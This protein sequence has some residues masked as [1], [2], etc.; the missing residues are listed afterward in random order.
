MKIIETNLEGCII[1]EPTIFEDKRGYFFESFNHQVFN[2]ITNFN[3]VFVQDNEAF[4]RKGAL[5]GMHYQVGKYSQ[6]KLVRVLEGKVLDVVVDLRKDS[7]TFGES[8]SIE[9]S[10][11]N[12]KQL[13]VPRGFAHGYVVLSDTATFFYKCDNIYKKESEGGIKYND[14][15]LKIDWRL[16]EKE[17]IISDKY[18]GLPIFEKCRR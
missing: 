12:K 7:I 10:S 17:L 2:E 11:E 3:V 9:L 13:F 6:A 4:S 8:F 16:A 15:F 5:R 18:K 1:I 14:G